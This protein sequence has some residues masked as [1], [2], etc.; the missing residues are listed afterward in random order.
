MYFDSKQNNDVKYKGISILYQEFQL[1]DVIN[2]HINEDLEWGH[3][4]N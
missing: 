3:M 2:A 4:E 1:L